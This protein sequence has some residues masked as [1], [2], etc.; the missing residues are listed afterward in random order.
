MAL[1]TQTQ[2]LLEQ[3]IHEFAKSQNNSEIL[4]LF[5]VS[6]ISYP[7]DQNRIHTDRMTNLNSIDSTGP[8]STETII[9]N[10]D[11]RL[12]INLC[13]RHGKTLVLTQILCMQ[14]IG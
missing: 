14:K 11:S 10:D 3:R 6:S 9:G 8:A 12:A 5:R 7:F 2:Q 13:T 4:G 1:T